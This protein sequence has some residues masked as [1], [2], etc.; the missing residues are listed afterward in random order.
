[1]ATSDTYVGQKFLDL[2]DYLEENDETAV[3]REVK[4]CF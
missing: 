3:T 2:K 4:R 1:M